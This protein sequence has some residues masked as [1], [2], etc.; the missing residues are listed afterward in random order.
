[1]K[2]I[3]GKAPDIPRKLIE[4]QENDNLLFFCGAGISYPAGLP[5]FAGLVEKVYEELATDPSEPEK[6]G[7]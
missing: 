1:M 5:L 6:K 4:A 2:F 7:N 3:P